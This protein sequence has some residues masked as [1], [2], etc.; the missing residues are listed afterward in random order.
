[1]N[2]VQL[3]SNRVVFSSLNVKGLKG[4]F[5]Y[6]KYLSQFSSLVF[7]CELWTK[8]TDINLIKEIASYSDKNFVYKSDI[9]HNYKKGR[10]Y[11]G[12][13]W[14]IDKKFKILENKLINRYLSYLHFKI[15]NQELVVIGVYMPFDDS[16]NRNES[17]SSF[18]L[19][20]NII[21]AINEEFKSSKTPVIITGDF[22]S[23]VNRD[24]RFDQTLKNFI[25]DQNFYLLDNLN[26]KNSSTFKSS[27]INNKIHYSNIDHFILNGL[28]IPSYFESP[29]FQ[30][31]EDVGNLSDHNAIFFSF[32]IQTISNQFDQTK[33]STAAKYSKKQLRL[34][35]QEVAKLF[36]DKVEF[37]TLISFPELIE[38]KHHQV[39]S[40]E[41]MDEVYLK[42]SN[43]Y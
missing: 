43:I 11:G 6:T 10:P 36:T 41:E 22:N 24:N 14:L 9:D 8:P 1:M 30:V 34:D 38:N 35:N 31:L 2:Q 26:S 37:K 39:F 21:L 15:H 40:Q 3:N 42:I 20:L 5:S 19:I 23:D 27:Q 17:K 7:L 33:Q 28:V 12:Q 32:S 18:E 13:C 16:K 29:K 25:N 4:N